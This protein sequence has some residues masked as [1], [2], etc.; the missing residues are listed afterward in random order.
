M[1]VLLLELLREL[2]LV[3]P[4][5]KLVQPLVLLLILLISMLLV[6]KFG[7]LLLLSGLYL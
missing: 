7:K 6:G 4:G 5:M 2:I 1:V 3:L